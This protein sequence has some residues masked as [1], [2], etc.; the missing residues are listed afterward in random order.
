MARP[1]EQLRAVHDLLQSFRSLATSWRLGQDLSALAGA[2]DV[3]V[4]MIDTSIVRVHQHGSCVTRN[5]RQSMGRFRGGLTGKIHALVDASGLPVRL[6]VT[7]GEAHDNRLAG[8][9]LSRLR[10]G[11]M[12]LADRGL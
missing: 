3:A 12:L 9:L 6:A 2:H 5:R 1:A 10:V 4:Q 8:K 11:S 7:P